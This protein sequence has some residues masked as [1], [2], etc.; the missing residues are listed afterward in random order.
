MRRDL[1]KR[2][3]MFRD[4]DDAAIGSIEKLLIEK[5]YMKDSV[6]VGQKDPG[7]ALFILAEGRG[8]VSLYGPGGREVIL[9]IFK[10]GDFFGEMSIIDNQPRS[11]S[12]IAV[13]DSTLLILE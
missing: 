13:E 5:R 4:L 12:V 9:S 11:A 1:L 6:I 8:K 3:S 10:P 7:D 2:V